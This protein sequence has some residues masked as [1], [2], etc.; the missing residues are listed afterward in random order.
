M[1]HAIMCPQCNAPLKPSKFARTATCAYCGATIR[2]ESGTRSIQAEQFHESFRVWNSPETYPVPGWFLIKDKYWGQTKLLM[3]GD[4]SDVFRGLRARWPTELVV[5][6]IQ[7]DK[8][9]TRLEREW[10]VL[11]ILMQSKAS[12]ADLFTT[13][14]PQPVMH[15]KIEGG[16]HMGFRANIFRW[17]AGFKHSF[18]EVMNA[19][20]HGIQPRA[21]IW[22]WRR[23]LEMLS[24]I[25][26]SGMVHGSVVPAHMLVQENDH[27]VKLIG[28]SAAGRAGSALQPA[29]TQDEAFRPPSIRSLSPVLDLAMSARS[30][31]AILGGDAEAGSIP[32]A[33]PAKLAKRLDQLADPAASTSTNAWT[34]REELGVIARDVFGPPQFNPIVMPD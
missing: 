16:G 18:A 8:N 13:F 4:S 31:I 12:G 22:I 27:G 15:G 3:R 7:R 10:E 28:Y 33:V 21:S 23:V 9:K 14:L 24:F 6:K 34:L 1:E 25:H 19:Y 5:I 2:L 11:Q 29:G 20:P 17:S 26:N 32:D 30:M